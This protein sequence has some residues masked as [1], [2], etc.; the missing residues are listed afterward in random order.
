MNPMTKE[1]WDDSYIVTDT[2]EQAPFW[3]DSPRCTLTTGDY[4]VRELTDK[5]SVERK[6]VSD[7]LG[8]LGGVRGVRRVRFEA[9]FERLGKLDRGAV[10]IEGGIA[11]IY[12]ARRFGRITPA[13]AVG[14]MISWAARYRVPVFF[15]TDRVAAKSVCKTYLRLAWESFQNPAS[16]TPS[17]TDKSVA[18]G[19]GKLADRAKLAN[20]AITTA[21]LSLGP[22]GMKIEAKR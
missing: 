14:A 15:C 8:S 19:Q 1:K 5:I 7:L 4:S 2:R 6:S 11:E 13:H 10:V 9:E 18:S 12:K 22:D 20:K 21:V 17:G 16:S 3:P